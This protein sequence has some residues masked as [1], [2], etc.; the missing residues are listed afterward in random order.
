MAAHKPDKLSISRETYN[1]VL[2][3]MLDAIYE[4]ESWSPHNGGSDF[5]L[6][7]AVY[8]ALDGDREQVLMEVADVLSPP[9]APK[10]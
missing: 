7:L 5:A 3:A 2:E 1:R 9:P 6:V 8:A 10:E 4:R